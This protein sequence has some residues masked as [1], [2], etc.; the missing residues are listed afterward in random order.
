MMLTMAPL[1]RLMRI[2]KKISSKGSGGKMTVW[3]LINNIELQ[4]PV[5][6]PEI[7][8]GLYTVSL[9]RPGVLQAV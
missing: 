3:F 1:A 8:G 2:A 6:D 7:N 9:I 4:I 5:M